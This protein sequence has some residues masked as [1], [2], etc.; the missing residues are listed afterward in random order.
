MSNEPCSNEQ[1]NTDVITT[2][3]RRDVVVP[4]R[5]RNGITP[6]L[7]NN[8]REFVLLFVPRKVLARILF[9]RV[10]QK[11]LTH[12]RNE[13]SGF[14]PKKSTVGRILAL[15]LTER[16][17]DFRTGLLAALVDLR[18]V[19]DSVNRDVHWTILSFRGIPRKIVRRIS[20]LY[21]GTECCKM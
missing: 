10:R 6:F 18:K 14:T 3:W 4:I 19:F 16:L 15:L 7:C 2:D 13:Q 1:W 20:G 9:D 5:K 11:L 17:C 8:Y 21:F 12:Q